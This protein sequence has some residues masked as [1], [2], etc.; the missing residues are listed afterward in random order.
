MPVMEGKAVLFKQFADVDAFSICLSTQD[1][2]EISTVKNI[3]M[4]FGGINP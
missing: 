4:A 1:T 3:E 2:E